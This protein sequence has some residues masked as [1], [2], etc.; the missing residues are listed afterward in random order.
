MNNKIIINLYLFF[1]VF[2]M[3]IS[4]TLDYKIDLTN[5]NRFTLTPSTVSLVKKIK[6]EIRIDVFLS[7]DL[8]SSYRKL[9][10]ETDELLNSFKSIN[11][12][13]KVNF[14]NPF[15]DDLSIE[16]LISQM[17]SYGMKPEYIVDAK[18]QSIEKKIV[19]PWAILNDGNQSVLISLIEASLG[20]SDEQKIINGIEQ[21]E[22]KI[23]NGIQRLTNN[24]KTKLAFI[25]S[26]GTSSRLKISDWLKSLQ[27]YYEVSVFDFKKY[28]H[29]PKETLDNLITYPLLIISNPKEIFT[30]EEKFILDQYQINGGNILWLID[31]IKINIDSLFKNNGIA[32]AEKNDIGLDDYFFNYGLRI[33]TELVKDMYCAP[34][35]I[36]N[37]K[38]NQT[39]YVPFPWVY[40][41]MSKPKNT[42]INRTNIGSLWFRFVSPIDTLTSTMNHNYLAASSN[43][44]Q[45]QAIP[46]VVDL[47]SAINSLKP[48]KFNLKSKPFAVLSEGVYQSLFKNRISPI[49][50]INKKNDG[51]SKLILI[52]D[53]QFG[54]N[55]TEND[56]PLE[57]GYDKWTNN[58]YSN[59]KFL[60][61]SVHYLID[62]NFITKVRSK[63]IKINLFNQIKVNNRSYYGYV[64]ILITPLLALITLNYIVA[65]RQ[66]RY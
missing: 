18:N 9:S 7:G 63:K 21:L 49:K 38:G 3:L 48:D 54:E 34:L 31:R 29:N 2:V 47:S 6:Q 39:Q 10:I 25:T 24:S 60:M 32:V 59:K 45:L 44:I 16:D 26:H 66:K 55:Q 8:P 33:N 27:M 40:Y 36:A 57:L 5:N 17:A 52:S 37:G 19:F 50:D 4:Q 56:N 35:V 53:G 41:P 1:G 11:N 30:S 65:K 46:S 61:N 64:L 13:F 42:I 12:N 62:Q 22:Y 58:F 23:I 20:D 14:I 51:I 15:N 28:K 43:Y